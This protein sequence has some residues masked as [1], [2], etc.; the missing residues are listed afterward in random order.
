MK[1]PQGH[2]KRGFEDW[3]CLLNPSIYGLRQTPKNWN[4]TLHAALLVLLPIYV[5]DI[6]IIGIDQDF[7]FVADK[8]TARFSVKSLG[9]VNYLL[10]LQIVYE[11]ES[12]V[13][14]KQTKYVQDIMKKFQMDKAYPV[15]IPM[16]T[17]A[18]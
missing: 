9:T 8:L 11:P 18:G 6:L 7:G 3:V 14:F 16:A 5:D 13:T 4:S 15:S 2:V 10:G 1:Q 17:D 12:C